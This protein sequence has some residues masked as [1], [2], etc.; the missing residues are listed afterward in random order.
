MLRSFSRADGEGLS[1]RRVAILVV[2]LCFLA[3]ALANPI[4]T[5][6]V[7]RN[8]AAEAAEHHEELVEEIEELEKKK[9]QLEDSEYIRAQARDRL[10][11]VEEGVTPYIVELPGDT[12]REK[13][14]KRDRSDDPDPWYSTVWDSVSEGVDYGQG[15][16]DDEDGGDEGGGDGPAADAPAA[17][18]PLPGV[19]QA[20]PDGADIG[21]GGTGAT[22]PD[23]GSSQ[24]GGG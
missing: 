9:D 10:G 8:D 16:A 7:Q 17:D 20:P 1:P 23:D 6:F 18:D 11:F 21:A 5:Y 2:L 24:D 12:G 15:P 22:D 13:T 14:R 19:G 4:R 3:L